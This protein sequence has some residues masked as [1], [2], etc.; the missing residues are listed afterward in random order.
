[1]SYKPTITVSRTGAEFTKNRWLNLLLP[2]IDW[3]TGFRKLDELY[4]VHKFANLGAS[5]F[6]ERLI[7]LLGIKL[8]NTQ[9]LLESVP[10]TGPCLLVANHPLGAIEG[11][12]LAQLLSTV[13]SDVKILANRRLQVFS[14]L[15]SFFIY[16]DPL[17]R[18]AQGNL[19]SLRACKQHLASGGLLVVFPAGRVATQR[20]DSPLLQDYPWHRAIQCLL[21]MRGLVILPVF[22]DGRNSK[23]FYRLG[24]IHPHLRMMTLMREMLRAKGRPLGF[25]PA[26]AVTDM[27]PVAPERNHG[28]DARIASLRLLT[29]L[30]NPALIIEHPKEVASTL[31]PLAPPIAKARLT[32][33]LY[34]LPAQQCLIKAG[35]IAVFY[36]AMQQTPGV[37]SEIQRLRESV[38]RELDEGSGQPRDG[39]AFDQMYVH[40]YLFDWAENQIVGAC[41]LGR[42]DELL[43]EGGV[44]SLYLNQMFFFGA[45]FINRTRPCLEM[46]R[47]FIIP[48]Y[49]RS[50]QALQL[51]FKGIGAFIRLFPQYQTLYGT[52]SISQQY[53][54]LS[55]LLIREATLLPNRNVSARK[56]L[57]WPVPAEMS[58]YLQCVAPE[59]PHLD[60]L[61]RQLEHDGKGLPV[62]L[63]HY[64]NMNATFY[65]MG[66]DPNFA[67]TPGL[68]LSVDLSGLGVKTRKR[69]LS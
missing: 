21:D 20:P 11:V 49:Q 58:E 7:G 61:V 24:N 32:E 48:G 10:S 22:I 6:A 31:L 15:E 69:F 12:A 35:N 9:A 18:A 40:L 33:E 41:R 36:S 47:S 45:D 34:A 52:V 67:G 55:T 60:W 8:I 38:F 29:F 43:R 53:S 37:V 39:D 42:S 51:M 5:A 50:Y 68:L 28:S 26:N 59:L 23:L 54:P 66:V 1:M 46:G 65:A 16:T 27:S 3:L 17:K 19:S 30:K 14:E 62:L 13:R 25:F 63:R 56:A 4:H 64:A 2:A 57:P 44:D